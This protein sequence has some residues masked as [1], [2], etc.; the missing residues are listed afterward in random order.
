MQIISTGNRIVNSYLVQTPRGYVAVDSGYRD[1][2]PAYCKTL[3]QNNIS[4]SDIRYLFLTHS[5]DDHV[6]FMGELLAATDAKLILHRSA[7]ARI[8][9]GKNF[10]GKYADRKASLVS[11]LMN[12]TGSVKHGFDPIEE[13]SR[14][15]PWDGSSQPLSG[16]GLT[17][18][19]LP[20]H[21]PDSIGLLTADGELFCGDAAMNGFPSSHRISIFLEDPSQYAKSWDTILASGSSE[22]YPGHGAPFAADDLRNFREYADR[23]RPISKQK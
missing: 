8:A 16:F 10:P 15:I 3:E 14:M 2:F 12:L 4:L 17:V 11:G 23:I 19:A 5:H 22:L 21:T 9:E 20:G 1:G 13:E 6:G 7:V 18:I